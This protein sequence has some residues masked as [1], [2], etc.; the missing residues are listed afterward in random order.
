[1]GVVT[2][3]FISAEVTAVVVDFTPEVAVDSAAARC[4][5]ERALVA[6]AIPGV[7]DAT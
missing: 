3:E 2:V 4:M 7:A 6:P 5:A 1:M